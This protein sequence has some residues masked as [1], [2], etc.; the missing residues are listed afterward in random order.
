MTRG[1]TGF[2][3]LWLARAASGQWH[4]TL[5][6]PVM[7][8][9]HDTRTLQA[10]D[11]YVALRGHRVDGHHFLEEAF[12][13]GAL[14]ALVDQDYLGQAAPDRRMGPLL[15]VPD[16]LQALGQMASMHRHR[17]GAW[18][19]GITGSMGKTTVKD[20]TAVLLRQ[21]GDTVATHGNWNNAIG[22]PLSMLALQPATRFGVFEL[23]MN[24]PGEIA[25]LSRILSPDWGIVTAIGPVHLEFFESVTGIAHEKS[26][27]LQALPQTGLAF[28]HAGDAYYDLLRAAAPCPVR[29]LRVG[30]DD[31]AADLHVTRVQGRLQAREVGS[32]EAV[33]LPAPV[34]GQHNLVNAGLALLVARAAG[35]SWDQ[36]RQGLLQYQPPAM[37]WEVRNVGGFTVVNDAYNANPVSMQ[38]ALATFAE[39]QVQGRKWLV[40]GDMLELGDYAVEAHRSLGQQVAAGD[41]AGVAVVGLHARTVLAAAQEAGFGAEHR[42]R[43]ATV[44]EAGQWLLPRLAPGDAILLK[45]SRGLGLEALVGMFASPS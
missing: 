6:Q 10:G 13:K 31:G 3:G 32:D 30:A 8:I 9:C 39:M 28:L 4:G 18:I 26:A 35:L 45:G 5:D 25:S 2:D 36:I 41:W 20:M 7:R 40:L 38:G 11:L 24:H 23:G 16:T 44:R 42:D 14:A 15:V 34:P 43:F 12:R 29:T 21:G 37:R 33:L 17:V 22:L 27:L 1:V 19:T